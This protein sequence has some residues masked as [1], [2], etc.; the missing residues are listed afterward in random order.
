LLTAASPAPNTAA[1]H[2]GHSPNDLL[3]AQMNK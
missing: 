2:D 1:G 3:N